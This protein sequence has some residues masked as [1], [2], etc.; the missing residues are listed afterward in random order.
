M[1]L[2]TKP[3]DLD[4]LSYHEPQKPSELVALSDEEMFRLL[5]K[6][7][8]ANLWRF[9]DKVQYEATAR[10]IAALKDFK[11]SSDRTG[12]ALIGLTVVLVVLTGVLVWLTLRLD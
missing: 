12:N 3:D 11:R 7:A 2:D 9:S 5:R 6:T 8:F 10:L 1:P 4:D